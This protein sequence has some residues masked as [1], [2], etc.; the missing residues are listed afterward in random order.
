MP[1]VNYKHITVRNKKYFSKF[2]TVSNISHLHPDDRKKVRQKI[3]NKKALFV[4][5]KLYK[6]YKSK[7]NKGKRV[8]YLAWAL[9]SIRLPK[10]ATGISKY[11]AVRRKRAA[12]TAKMWTVRTRAN[13]RKYIK[14]PEG[15]KYL[16]KK[17]EKKR[18]AAKRRR[19][20]RKAA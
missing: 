10:T 9:Q 20:K 18:N 6:K 15:W 7:G 1:E 13:G 19:K 5:G 16:S 2:R 14:T 17:A 11:M 12:K 8:D 3:G 4:V